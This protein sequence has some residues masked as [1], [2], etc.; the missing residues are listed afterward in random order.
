METSGIIGCS[1]HQF[2]LDCA[3]DPA[4]H[5]VMNATLDIHRCCHPHQASLVD[6]SLT[7]CQHSKVVNRVGLALVGICG[8]DNS[9]DSVALQLSHARRRW[10]AYPFVSVDVT[11]SLVCTVD[12]QATSA[13]HSPCL[14]G[15]S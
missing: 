13:D 5:L 15:A 8:D 7:S 9:L 6:A 11:R 2:L 14:C 1:I 4:E 10:M 12:M 3:G